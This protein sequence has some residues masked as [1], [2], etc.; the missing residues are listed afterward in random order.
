[1][2]MT[3]MALIL[4]KIFGCHICLGGFKAWILWL[5]SLSIFGWPPSSPLIRVEDLEFGGNKEA[6]PASTL[7][8]LP[9]PLQSP[10][11]NSECGQLERG[12]HASRATCTM[13]AMIEDFTAKN[14]GACLFGCTFHRFGLISLRRRQ[15]LTSSV[16]SI[17]AQF[18][19]LPHW[20]S[21]HNWQSYVSNLDYL[22]G[23]CGGVDC[24][25][26]LMTMLQCSI[27]LHMCLDNWLNKLLK[28][29]WLV[30]SAPTGS[31]GCSPQ[32]LSTTCSNVWI[33]EE[34]E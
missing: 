1:M 12:D 17:T 31:L 7:L 15:L 32:M 4:Q 3:L 21:N 30:L 24:I 34:I 33:G 11:D 22:H 2:L 29:Y 18:V 19:A 23:C 25:L 6:W 13:V 14:H 26:S 16:T 20:A 27:W 5:G 10:G 8:P 28:R 9:A